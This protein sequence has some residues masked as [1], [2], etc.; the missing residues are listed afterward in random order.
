MADYPK[1]RSVSDWRRASKESRTKQPRK[2]YLRPSTNSYPYMLWNA[3]A[4]DYRP[5][6]RMLRSV[7][8]LSNLHGHKSVNRAAQ[9]IMERLQK[10]KKPG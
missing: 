6:V 5:S 3:T 4:N 9:H 1:M 8:A 10:K 7:I 2:V